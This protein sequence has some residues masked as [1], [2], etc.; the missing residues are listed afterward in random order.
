MYQQGIPKE[1]VNDDVPR[2]VIDWNKNVIAVQGHPLAG[3]THMTKRDKDKF[4]QSF[5]T[6]DQVLGP[7]TTNVSCLLSKLFVIV[8]FV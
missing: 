4:K 8:D 7:E 1:A 6:F 3:G 5:Y 2:S